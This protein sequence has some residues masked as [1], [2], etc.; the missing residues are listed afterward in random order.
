MSSR[1]PLWLDSTFIPFIFLPFVSSSFLRLSSSSSFLTLSHFHLSLSLSLFLSFS[2]HFFFILPVFK[3]IVSF[4]SHFF[5]SSGLF[6][7]PYFSTYSVFISSGLTFF[8]LSSR[9]LSCLSYSDFLSGLFIS[10]DISWPMWQQ[11]EWMRDWMNERKSFPVFP[12]LHKLFTLEQSETEAWEPRSRGQWEEEDFFVT[13]ENHMK[14]SWRKKDGKI[15]V[16]EKRCE[17]SFGSEFN[18]ISFFFISSFSFFP[19]SW[20]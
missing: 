15:N 14:L 3:A 8:L 18:V 13:Y 16:E 1:K 10:W 5:L 19:L 11:G 12:C 6:H 17:K 7:A 4:P 2:P 20:L 9:F